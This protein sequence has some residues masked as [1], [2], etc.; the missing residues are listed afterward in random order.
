MRWEGQVSLLEAQ[1]ASQKPR[2]G[3]TCEEFVLPS[4]QAEYCV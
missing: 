3:R 2:E 4:P 1:Q